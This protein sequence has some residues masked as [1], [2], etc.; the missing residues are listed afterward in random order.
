[1]KYVKK[2]DGDG[3]HYTDEFYLEMF[4]LTHDEGLTYVEAYKQLGFDTKE[5]GERRAVQAGY[6]AT[7]FALEKFFYGG[8]DS[9]IDLK[10]DGGLTMKEFGI[11]KTV[12][13]DF[14][15]DMKARKK[16]LKALLQNPFL[17]Q[18]S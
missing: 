15:A 7:R 6:R 8:D 1:M 12:R 18:K 11:S 14:R 9:I 17:Q 4:R 2:I 5:L 10:K 3:I 13:E 16:F